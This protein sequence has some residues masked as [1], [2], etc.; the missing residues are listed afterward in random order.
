ML[1]ATLRGWRRA[2]WRLFSDRTWPIP[3]SKPADFRC[4]TSLA[5]ATVYVN[6]CL[7]AAA[8]CQ[9][10]S[11]QLSSAEQPCGWDRQYVRHARWRPKRAFPVHGGEQRARDF[12]RTPATMRSLRTRSTIPRTPTSN[13]VAS[14][15]VL[16]VYLTGQGAL[17]H[18]GARWNGH[19]EFAALHAPRPR[20]P[21]PSAEPAQRCSFSD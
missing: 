12:S 1:P 2:S 6:Q 18:A 17:N 5:G 19:A 13:P 7:G 4:R 9:R 16:V 10:N 21:P 8:L 11:D 20:R 14:G 15:A 3:P